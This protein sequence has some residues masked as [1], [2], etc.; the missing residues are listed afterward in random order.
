M[1]GGAESATSSS[2]GNHRSLQQRAGLRGCHSNYSF[3]SA[4]RVESGS[5]SSS[6][7]SS[8]RCCTT[9]RHVTSKQA[10]PPVRVE[11]GAKHVFVERRT[12]FAAGR[13]CAC[14]KNCRASVRRAR[15]SVRA[16]S[17][18]ERWRTTVLELRLR[19]PCVGA[20]HPRCMRSISTR[21]LL[22]GLTN[23][24]KMKFLPPF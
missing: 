24:V 21:L 11:R 22:S 8:R 10:A 23:D 2:T 18:E 6:S 17:P 12:K 7:S 4:K 16:L 14:S 1:S 13:L 5:S 3:R 15:V 20:Q 19:P 9:C